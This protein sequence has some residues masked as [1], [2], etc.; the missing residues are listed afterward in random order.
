MDVARRGESCALYAP[1]QVGRKGVTDDATESTSVQ[2]LRHTGAASNRHTNMDMPSGGTSPSTRFENRIA[3][4]RRGRRD[5]DRRH[6][7][8]STASEV[9]E[10][11]GLAAWQ[12]KAPE[13]ARSTT[14]STRSSAAVGEQSLKDGSTS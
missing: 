10:E 2:A 8:K 5:E 6:G 13:S 1:G 9:V 11:E 4:P 12:A 3:R 7:G 14:R